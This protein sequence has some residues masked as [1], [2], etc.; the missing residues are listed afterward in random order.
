MNV[1]DSLPRDSA[2]F[3]VTGP[4]GWIGQAVLAYLSR[5]TGGPLTGRVTLFASGAR[6]QHLPSGET[7]PVRPLASIT[8]ADTADAHVV[9]LAYLTKEKA[10]E[11]GERR[12]SETNIAIDDAVLEAIEAGVPRSIF[13]ASS[14][15]A[16]L[17]AAGRD[18]HPYGLAK[19]R[20][21]ARFLEAAK[22]AAIP[23]LAGRIFN[24]AGPYINKLE[25]Y[26]ISNFVQQAR[27]TGRIRIAAA[28]PVFRSFLHVENLAA[29]IHAAAKQGI[30]RPMPIDLCGGEIVEM[31]DLAAKVAEAYGEDIAIERGLVD[32]ARPSLYLGSYA[33]TRVLGMETDISLASLRQQVIDT[34]SWISQDRI[35]SRPREKVAGI[36]ENFE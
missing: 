18:L 6:T 13:V 31:A 26:A 24:L 1:A 28:S 34:I 8:S 30:G 33:D 2:R 5:V 16:R 12:F 14:G 17:A 11:L 22:K 27:D 15:A 23:A 36:H 10:E 32:F 3:V 7:L 20:Q 25:S 21:E 19:L 9:H 29:L 35:A 4:S